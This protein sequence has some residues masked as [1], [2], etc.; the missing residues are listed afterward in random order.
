LLEAFT[1]PLKR[2]LPDMVAFEKQMAVT[3]CY[4]STSLTVKSDY[5]PEKL[6]L[7]GYLGTRQFTF[8]CNSFENIYLSFCDPSRGLITIVFSIS[9]IL[10]GNQIKPLLDSIKHVPEMITDLK[11]SN[12][13]RDLKSQEKNSIKNAIT[14]HVE[15]IDVYGFPI[16]GYDEQQLTDIATLYMGKHPKIFSDKELGE[17]TI[18]RPDELRQWLKNNHY[19]DK[20]DSIQFK[21][22]SYYVFKMVRRIAHSEYH[23][24][25]RYRTA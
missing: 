23:M 20:L 8:Q 25:M 11:T 19:F 18:H 14:N 22:M 12:G 16:D 24:E 3:K 13:L 15:L 5:Y 17:R 2:Y 4:E 7:K 9:G 1:T 10:K 21:L 6:I